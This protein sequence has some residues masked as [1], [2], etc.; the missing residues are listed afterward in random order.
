[1]KQAEKTKHEEQASRQ[2]PFMAL[3]SVPA[4]RPLPWVPDPTSLDD[5]LGCGSVS[6]VKPFLYKFNLVM[7]FYHGRKPTEHSQGQVPLKSPPNSTHEE[8]ALKS[9]HIF[10]EFCFDVLVCVHTH[11][12]FNDV[13]AQARGWLSSSIAFCLIYEG[14]I[15]H[16][17]PELAKS[18]IFASQLALGLPYLHFLFTRVTGRPLW[19][20]QRIWI[21]V[22]ML[23]RQPLYPLRCLPSPSL[24][25]S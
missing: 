12:C 17:N 14:S 1:M 10:L 9:S 23:G 3:V 25:N 16:L 2:C 20:W 21:P 7:V 5:K 15:L 19:V 4:S 13:C 24:V 6:Q 8:E 18:T 22:F 11:A